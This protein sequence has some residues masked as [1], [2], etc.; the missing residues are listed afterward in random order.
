MNLHIVSEK[1]PD[2]PVDASVFSLSQGRSSPPGACWCALPRPDE[3]IRSIKEYTIRWCK[4]RSNIASFGHYEI[5]TLRWC[6]ARQLGWLAIMAREKHLIE[7]DCARVTPDS[8]AGACAWQCR[9]AARVWRWFPS[10]A[11]RSGECLSER[12]TI[13]FWP[14]EM[15]EKFSRI[16]D[17]AELWDF[18]DAPIAHI[19]PDVGAPGLCRC[20]RYKAG[21]FDHRRSAF[22]RR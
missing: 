6:A 2:T 22:S 13:G 14:Q 9:A 11:D 7:A 18:I 4:G 17:F 1:M 12:R 21:Y 10:R 16:V 19:H 8:G 20:H 5:S 3:R 15:D